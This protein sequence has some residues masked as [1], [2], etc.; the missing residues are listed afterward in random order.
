MNTTS[1]VV[2]TGSIR[3]HQQI[4]SIGRSGRPVVLIAT[5]GVTRAAAAAQARTIASEL[6]L[7]LFR[8]DLGKVVSKY[9]RETEKNLR[10]LFDQAETG[11]VVLLFDEADAL[12]GKRTDVKDAHDRYANQEVAY[13]VSRLN[14][15]SDVI[16]LAPSGRVDANLLPSGLPRLVAKATPAV[17]RK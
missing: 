10:R 8:V 7:T 13:L 2:Q 1:A 11:G 12:F 9:I 3:F 4:R 6:G 16:A 5:P 15:L 17:P 14:A